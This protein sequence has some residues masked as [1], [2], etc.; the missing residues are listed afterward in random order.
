MRLWQTLSRS[1]SSGCLSGGR[2]IE[3]SPGI[4]SAVRA[5]L[6]SALSRSRAR[7]GRRPRDARKKLKL[8]H[9]SLLAITNI[10]SIPLPR[11]PFP[12]LF[13]GL[14]LRRHARGHSCRDSSPKSPLCPADRHS[15]ARGASEGN[16]GPAVGH[17]TS[18]EGA[19]APNASMPR[20]QCHLRTKFGG[21]ARNGH[22]DAASS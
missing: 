17:V 19:E 3:V 14:S 20:V 12:L 15:S 7:N 10:G 22:L 16:D 2:V 4:L 9:F 18:R 6:A 8:L 21:F 1:R 11:F 13:E 5:L